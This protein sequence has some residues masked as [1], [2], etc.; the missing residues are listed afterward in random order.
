MNSKSGIEVPIFAI[1]EDSEP[2]LRS[3]SGYIELLDLTIPVKIG[4]ISVARSAIPTLVPDYHIT[5]ALIDRNLHGASPEG[6]GDGEEIAQLLMKFAGGIMR[7]GIGAENINGVDK[8]F[9]KTRQ[10]DLLDWLD[11]LVS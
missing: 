8:N 10:G 11:S 2:F 3:I 1:F 7:I 9:P 4:E 5:H 6:N